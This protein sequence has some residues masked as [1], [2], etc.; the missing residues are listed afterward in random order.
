MQATAAFLLL[1][2]YAG[3]RSTIPPKRLQP[4]V[5]EYVR[6]TKK[7]ELEAELRGLGAGQAPSDEHQGPLRPRA[8]IRTMLT[9][10]RPKHLNKAEV[11]QLLSDAGLDVDA[12]RHT[13]PACTPALCNPHL[14]SALLQGRDDG[15]A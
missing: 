6:V 2:P 11:T 7:R 9:R 8:E 15:V 13:L 4:A 12:P 3:K 10:L 5:A 1:Q 14:K